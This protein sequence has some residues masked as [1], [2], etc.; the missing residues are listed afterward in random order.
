MEFI[1]ENWAR[2]AMPKCSF[3]L[4]RESLGMEPTTFVKYHRVLN[5]RLC[6]QG[7]MP[8]LLRQEDTSR[9]EPCWTLAR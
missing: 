2:E 8:M 5:C 6:F 1:K 4:V 3:V 9:R 7:H